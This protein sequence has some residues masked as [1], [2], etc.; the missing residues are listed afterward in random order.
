MLHARV[1]RNAANA[2][3]NQAASILL[4]GGFRTFEIANSMAVFEF[5]GALSGLVSDVAISSEMKSALQ[6]CQR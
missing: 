4:T 1:P 6:D 2:I 5:S 3:I